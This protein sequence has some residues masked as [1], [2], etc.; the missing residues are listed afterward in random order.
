MRN[1]LIAAVALA[2]SLVVVAVLAGRDGAPPAASPS[3]TVAAATPTAATSPSATPSPSRGATASPAQD[4]FVNAALRY[5]LALPP[6]LW[7]RSACG[8]WGP[9]TSGGGPPRGHDTF[10]GVPEREYEAWDVGGLAIDHVTVFVERN[11]ERLSPRGWAERRRVVFLTDVTFAGRPAVTGRLESDFS[12]GTDAVAV[13]VAQGDVMYQ[14]TRV[15]KVGSTRAPELDTIVASFRLEP[16]A[17]AP[18]PTP[19]ASP[20]RSAEQLADLLADAFSRK[21][22]AALERM[23]TGCVTQGAAQGGASARPREPYVEMLR[24]RFARGLTVTVRTRPLAQWSPG[25]FVAESTWREPG[26]PDREADL[27]L[28]PDGAAWY[29]QGV[30]TYFIPRPTRSP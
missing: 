8:T 17:V 26:Q 21:D 23:L 3:P 2:L 20:A 11:P 30:I 10:I 16:A 6:P 29:W 19:P 7:H 24:E 1:A 9:D 12:P 4:R 14:V 25:A 5:S 13:F 18:A 28:V 22:P 15:A 27:I